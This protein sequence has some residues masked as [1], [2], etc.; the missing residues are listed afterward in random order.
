MRRN[1]QRLGEMTTRCSMHS[2]QRRPGTARPDQRTLWPACQM[3]Q[4]RVN[5]NPGRGKSVVG[6][7]RVHG[8]QYLSPLGDYAVHL[9]FFSHMV[10]LHVYPHTHL[11]SP[12]LFPLPSSHAIPERALKQAGQLSPPPNLVT[13]QPIALPSEP[14]S[15][16]KFR[17]PLPP[18]PEPLL[19]LASPVVLR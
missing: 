4:C 10:P 15:R 9:A 3:R 12:N 5:Y 6:A 2:C 11:Q 17:T 14:S 19:G 1:P 18:R 16:P 13:V 7:S 8:M